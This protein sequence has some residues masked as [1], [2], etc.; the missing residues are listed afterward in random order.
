M[1]SIVYILLT[2]FISTI[3]LSA[4]P[5]VGIASSKTIVLQCTEA[6]SDE[7]LNQSVEIIKARL[8]SFGL[9]KFEVKGKKGKQSI[10]VV[11]ESAIN[12]SEIVSLLTSK[13]KLEFYETINK[14]IITNQLSKSD[15]LYSLMNIPGDGTGPEAILGYSSE[16]NR[17]KVETLIETNL[18]PGVKDSNIQFA[19][20]KF[21]VDDLGWALF[22]L[23]NNSLL[24]GK[25]VTESIANSENT[26]VMINFNEEG[27]K[28]WKDM[29]A[30]NINRVIA[31]VIDNEVYSA[32]MVRAAI[33]HGKCQISGDFSIT[34]VNR[35]VAFIDNGEL[36]LEF[37]VVK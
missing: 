30:R 2:V 15:E 37:K 35:L 16:K 13:G 27:S 6:Y 1:K 4:F 3:L 10:E 23:K 29:T 24:S 22:L 26:Y 9:D 8:E 31:I 34:D 25:Y 7:K 32:P 14:N 20:S 17:L 18:I 12:E 28:I 33:E 19:W 11:I 21:P 36:P 5:K